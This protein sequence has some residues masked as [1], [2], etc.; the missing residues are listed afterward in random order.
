MNIK[1]TCPYCGSNN[2]ITEI[3]IKIT[4]TLLEDGTVEI[5]EYWNNDKLKEIISETPAEFMDGFCKDCGRNFPF[6]WQR[7]FHQDISNNILYLV[8][9]GKIINKNH[10]NYNKYNIVYDKQRGYYDFKQYFTINPAEDIA[11]FKAKYKVNEKTDN[12][13]I[14]ISEQALI[15]QLPENFNINQKPE[16]CNYDPIRIAYYEGRE[17]GKPFIITG[18][19]VNNALA[20]KRHK[21]EKDNYEKIQNDTTEETIKQE[22]IIQNETVET[23]KT[24]NE[25]TTINTKE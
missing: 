5:K 9:Y 15:H 23:E 21:K 8:E 7:G 16:G 11:Q 12:Y 18:A 4:G 14:I 10:K 20:S 1:T 22:Q 2:V 19:P 6:T 17:N 13:Y 24:I 25:E 3:A